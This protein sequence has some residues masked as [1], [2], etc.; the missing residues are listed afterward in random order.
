MLFHLIAE[1]AGPVAV[2][3]VP[4]EAIRTRLDVEYSTNTP[5]VF[6]TVSGVCIHA[7]TLVLTK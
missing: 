4:H 7:D 5:D 3:L 6:R 1:V 2:G